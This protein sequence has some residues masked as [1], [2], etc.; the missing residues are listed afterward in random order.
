MRKTAVVT[1]VLLSCIW[2]AGGT[3]KEKPK[4]EELFETHCAKC[5]PDGDNII[6]PEKTLRKKDLN[7]NGIK[8]AADIVKLMRSPGPGMVPFDEKTISDKEAREIAEYVLKA[9]S[10]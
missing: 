6:N 2:A 4:G 9:F 7:A 10:K 5:H 1:T 8:T 3:A